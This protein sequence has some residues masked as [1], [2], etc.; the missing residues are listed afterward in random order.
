MSDVTVAE[1][2]RSLKLDESSIRKRIQ[3]G[4]MEARRASPRLWLISAEE[5]ERCK[6]LG[7][8]KPGPARRTPDTE[9]HHAPNG[10][11]SRV[12]SAGA[13]SPEE[14]APRRGTAESLLKYVGTWEGDDLEELLE[15]VYATRSQARF[16]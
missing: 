8:L 9:R 11:D 2:A 16:W 15:E 3:R 4:T 13:L 1:A 6:T 7:R 14:V 10:D 12:R 5:V